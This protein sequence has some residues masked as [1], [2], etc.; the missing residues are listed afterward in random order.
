MIYEFCLLNWRDQ[1]YLSLYLQ[2]NYS[3][4]FDPVSFKIFIQGSHDELETLCH[5]SAEDKKFESSLVKLK[6]VF[7]RK[8]FQS[9]FQPWE[10]KVVTWARL[11]RAVVED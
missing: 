10:D 1:V 9:E 4:H 5:S 8:Q 11:M 2:V 7:Y 6:K 3:L